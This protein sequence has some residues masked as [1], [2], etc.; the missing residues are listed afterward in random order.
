MPE[1]LSG[2]RVVWLPMSNP[3]GLPEQDK[4]PPAPRFSVSTDMQTYEGLLFVADL[5]NALDAAR[6]IKRH[7]KWGPANVVPRLV[8]ASL[9]GL[10]A[11]VGDPSTEEERATAIERAVK[12]ALRADAETKK[13]K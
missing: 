11:Q 10:L 6:G 5:W 7:R 13:R 12:E 2:A 4:G 8:R 3:Y 9:A 1:P